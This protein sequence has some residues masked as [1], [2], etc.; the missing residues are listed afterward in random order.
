MP[1]LWP[2]SAPVAPVLLVW[3]CGNADPRTGARLA[4]LEHWFEAGGLI[5]R[6]KAL[7]PARRISVVLCWTGGLLSESHRHSA[8]E[9]LVAQA[10]AAN[11]S[12]LVLDQPALASWGIPLADPAAPTL[13]R[14]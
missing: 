12:L 11:V 2:R 7:H 5:A 14:D 9:S 1:E 8:H 3:E 10:K 4:K 6:L 13:N